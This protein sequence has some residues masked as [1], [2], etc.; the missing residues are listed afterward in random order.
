M[1]ELLCDLDVW[2]VDIETK[3]DIMWQGPLWPQA[4][5]P[6]ASN[7]PCWLVKF[8]LYFKYKD[9]FLAIEP[10]AWLTIWLLK[11]QTQIG[12]WCRIP[13]RMPVPYLA[14]RRI[15]YKKYH[16]M[17]PCD[18]IFLWIYL[19]FLVHVSRSVCPNRRSMHAI[20]EERT[21]G[22]PHLMWWLIHIYQVFARLVP[23]ET[24]SCYSKWH[25]QQQKLL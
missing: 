14:L 1:Q 15:K 21:Y 16:L 23:S 8:L 4:M 5:S 13:Y 24:L 12:P 20:W 11:Y 9:L 18:L 22:H 2:S 3:T 25:L 17:G 19:M 10:L 7:F 6:N